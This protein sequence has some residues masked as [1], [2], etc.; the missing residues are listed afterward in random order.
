[1]KKKRS[2]K[3]RPA[4]VVIGAIIGIG[5]ILSLT[6][7]RFPLL[8][9]SGYS[10]AIYRWISSCL[11][12][13]T[14]IFPFSVAEV[15]VVGL[16]IFSLVQIIRGVIALVK[17]PREFLGACPRGIGKIALI[18]VLIYVGF[19]MLWG[20]NYSRL[21]FA[22]ISGLPVEPAAVEELTEL[23]L[24]LTEKANSLRAQV[25]ENDR[26][27]M[28]LSSG[29]RQMFAQAE[30]GYQRAA[31]FYPELGGKYGPPKGVFLSRY[32]SYTGISGMYFPFTAEA[33][34]NID[35]PHFML[36]AT[37]AHEMAHQRGFARED[38]ANFLSY[39]ACSLHPHVE[40]QYSGTMLALMNTMNALYRADRE[41][42]KN[43]RKQY[44][45]GINR[46]LK[47]WQ[48]Y[49]ARFEGPVQQLSTDINDSYLK[50]NRQQDG[51]RS[52]GRMV[53][54]LLAEFRQ[55]QEQEG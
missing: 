50:A 30:T 17:K 47:D 41:A 8:I 43:V 5:V 6:A 2:R 10:R 32:W 51:V 36:P 25:A 26:G 11:S 9:E 3:I 45:D 54:L 38:E 24:A 39:L 40:F 22:E 12:R 52:Y 13:L 7:P 53:D 44:C 23:A 16:V 15:T 46:D 42:Y 1:M 18:L 14:G 35:I 48:A 37:A 4:T 34:V 31:E 28:T 20:L 29:I 27:V 19:Y 49:W 21:S 55:A 33:N